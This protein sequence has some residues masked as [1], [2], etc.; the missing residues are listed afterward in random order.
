MT[1]RERVLALVRSEPSGLTDAEI[2]ERTG[3]EPHQQV[4]QICRNLAQT[5][6]IQRRPGPRGRLI[7]LPA[8]ALE[9]NS[10]TNQGRA[11]DI[12]SQKRSPRR[13]HAAH[14]TKMPRLSISKTLFVLPC[15]GTK[16][17]GGG[18]VG[19]N[20]TSVLDSLPRPLATELSARRAKN[21]PEAKVDESAL[22]LAAE[23]Y[24]GY[25]YQNA[26]DALGVLSEAG[27][28]TL[29]ISGG[30]GVVLPSEPIGWY[31]QRFQNSMWPNDLIARCLAHYAGA[32]GA[33]AVVG[34]LSATTQYAQI[35][36]RTPWADGVKQVFHVWP[37]PEAGAMVRAPRALGE[38]L[39]TLSQD[40]YFHPGWRSSDGLQMRVTRLK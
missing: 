21:A 13:P 5:G 36:R 6:L 40:H 25:L 22:L 19:G 4:N 12:G 38:A 17:R 33:L 16:R 27:A 2:R 28:D 15:S 23:R 26:G 30:Y 1:N 11:L 9:G 14:A 37:E 7:N 10:Q 3:I 35:F 39:K 20:G 8:G 24:T 32:I 29:I 18:R 34:L 31:E